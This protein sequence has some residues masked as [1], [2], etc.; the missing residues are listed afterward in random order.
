MII[1][2]FPKKNIYLLKNPKKKKILLN[3]RSSLAMIL[4]FLKV[5]KI[6]IPFY[7]CNSIINVLENLKISYEFYP[8]D[9]SLKPIINKKKERNFNFSSSFF[10]YSKIKHQ[11]KFYLRPIKFLFL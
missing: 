10:W 6:L 4:K 5:K 7:I 8:I 11:K 1:G 3:G 9:Q 2:G